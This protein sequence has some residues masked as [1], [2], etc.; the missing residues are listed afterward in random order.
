MPD[1]WLMGVIIYVS[2]VFLVN[3]KLIQDSN[4]VNWLIVI[5]MFLC[6]ACFFPVLYWVNRYSWDEMY[7]KFNEFFA[8]PTFYIL[9]GFWLLAPVPF[10]VAVNYCYL[11]DD[12]EQLESE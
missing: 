4:T 1:I 12:K 9:F 5:M 2:T 3:Q 6:S 10:Q 11:P 8:Y 7:G